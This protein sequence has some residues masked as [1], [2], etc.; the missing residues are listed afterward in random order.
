M[1]VSLQIC[2]LNVKNVLTRAEPGLGRSST[3]LVK[4][5]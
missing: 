2:I 3:N 1:L 4:Q 5:V